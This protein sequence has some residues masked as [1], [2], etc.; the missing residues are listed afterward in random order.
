MT[1]TTAK[2]TLGLLVKRALRRLK[3]EAKQGFDH[4]FF[5]PQGFNG[6]ISSTGSVIEHHCCGG[7]SW[8][9]ESGG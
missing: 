1:R 3:S 4:T 9:I 7:F 6:V 2:Q 8:R 5:I